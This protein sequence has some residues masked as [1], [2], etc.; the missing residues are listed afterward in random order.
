MIRDF[1][2]FCSSLIGRDGIYS[3][4]PQS[5]YT[6][7]R[8]RR[9]AVYSGFLFLATLDSSQRDAIKSSNCFTSNKW[10]FRTMNV[11]F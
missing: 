9:F 5:E 2:L 4:V 6:A 1:P 11:S 10:I 3:S 8:K 7:N